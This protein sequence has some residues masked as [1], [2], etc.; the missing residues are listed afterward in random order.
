MLRRA[1]SASRGRRHANT[2]SCG[3]RSLIWGASA[4]LLARAALAQPAPVG[5]PVGLSFPLPGPAGY[6][7]PGPGPSPGPS[8]ELNFINGSPIDSRITYTGSGGTFFN[9]AGVLTAATTNV[10]RFDFD[11]VTHAPLGLLIEEARTNLFLNSATLVTQTVTVTA[12]PF[13]LSFYGTGT[14]TLTGASIAGPLVGTGVA[15]RVSLTFTPTAGS[16]TATV[17]GSVTNAQIEAGGF[18]TSWIPTAGTAATRAVDVV[19]MPFAPSYPFGLVGEAMVS[20]LAPTIAEGLAVFTDG[21]TANRIAIRANAATTS[22]MGAVFV[23]GG[24]TTTVAATVNTVTPGTVF[25]VG[26][27]ATA[28][29]LTV[30]GNGGAPV[31]VAGAPPPGLNLLTL[32]QTNVPSGNSLN[33]YLRRLRYWPRA[34]TAAELQVATL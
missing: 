5:G 26:A 23:V 9:A 8:L 18:V 27:I 1:N 7:G 15:N 11:P 24:V 30:C 13:S 12:A 10:P 16:L 2:A 28:T 31:T 22:T 17:T 29:G 19:S 21:T 34:L 4:A 6:G 32:G 14:V 25:K 20:A 3:R 33:G